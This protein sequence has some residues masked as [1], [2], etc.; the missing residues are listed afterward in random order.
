M[1]YLG[2]ASAPQH[3]LSDPPPPY[4]EHPDGSQGETGA[5][6]PCPQKATD[7]DVRESVVND[8]RRSEGHSH[9][10]TEGS[11][12]AS[13]L[14]QAASSSRLTRLRESIAEKRRAKEAQRKVDFYQDIYGF[15]PKN[16]MTEAEWRQARDRAP[17][18][19]VHTP[20]RARV[21]SGPL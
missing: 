9:H 4:S 5:V 6:A 16:V 18:V 7:G 11:S 20:L 2:D 12:S 15:V 13:G 8:P 3:E 17:K 10:A 21:Y 19:K 14:P 1:N